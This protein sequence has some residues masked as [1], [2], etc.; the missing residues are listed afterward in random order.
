MDLLVSYPWGRYSGAKPEILR[1][2]HRFGDAAPAV[3]KT[4]VMGIALVH[5]CLDN[6]AVICQCREL[7][8]TEPNAFAL[9]VKWVPVDI[10]CDTGLESI[11]D[12]IV[13]HIADR[14]GVDETWA[15]K[16]HKRRW[17]VYH[18]AEIVEYLATAVE[19]TVNLRRPDRILWVDV[20]GRKTAVSLLEPQDIFSLACP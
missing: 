12:T 11:R 17:Q 7:R 4:A 14:I 5:T 18:T 10:W 8:K 6:R 16:V 19:R 9:A 3:E 20:I 13:Q 15:M 1:I 2:L